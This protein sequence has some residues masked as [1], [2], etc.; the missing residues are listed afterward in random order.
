MDEQHWHQRAASFGAAAEVY[1]RSRPSYP[2]DAVRA[3]LPADE[4]F[5]LPY[6]TVLWRS[7]RS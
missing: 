6:R 2:V 7:V 5:E 3:A 1:D 4:Q